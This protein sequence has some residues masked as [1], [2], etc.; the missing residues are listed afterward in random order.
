MHKKYRCFKDN[1]IYPGI[2]RDAIDHVRMVESALPIVGE[3]T[4]LSQHHPDTMEWLV[5]HG[6]IRYAHQ[7]CSVCAL[8]LG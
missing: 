4:L 7:N 2:C 1:E 3:F 5:P 6:W 8:S